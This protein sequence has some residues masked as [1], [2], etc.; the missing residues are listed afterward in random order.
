MFLSKP[1]LSSFFRSFC[2]KISYGLVALFFA[3][4]FSHRASAAT[5]L[6][7]SLSDSGTGTLRQAIL[8]ANANAGFDTV[9]FSVTGTINLLSALPDISDSVF[10]GG[11]GAQQLRVKREAL[12]PFFSVF[13]VLAAASPSTIGSLTISDGHASFGGGIHNQGNL[14]VTRCVIELNRAGSG[15]G[16]RNQG[17][18]TVS[19]STISSNVGDSFGGGIL[20]DLPGAQLVVINSSVSR[21]NSTVGGGVLVFGSDAL[22]TNSTLS[23]NAVLDTGAAISVSTDAVGAKCNRHSG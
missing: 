12:G 14:S 20:S 19:E 17:Q 3:M 10:I 15:G 7:S 5:F 6:V 22:I 2:A 16:I 9:N 4:G 21:N 23:A 18:L 13:T 11:P 1:F 8:D